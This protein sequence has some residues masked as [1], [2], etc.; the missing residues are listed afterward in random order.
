MQISG[1]R[2]AGWIAVVLALAAMATGASAAEVK[3]LRI[4]NEADATRAVLDVSGPLQYKLMTMQNPDRLVLDI[5][6]ATLV[7][8]FKPGAGTGVLKGVRTGRQGKDLRVVFDLAGG[9]RP[10]SFLL[11]PENK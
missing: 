10:K 7:A 11:P 2:F 9:V 6:G 3:A 5:A 4:S 1:A 8:G